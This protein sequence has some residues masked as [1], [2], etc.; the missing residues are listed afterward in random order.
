MYVLYCGHCALCN[1]KYIL[2]FLIL[3]LKSNLPRQENWNGGIPGVG[4]SAL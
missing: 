3:S 4:D 2:I 1:H